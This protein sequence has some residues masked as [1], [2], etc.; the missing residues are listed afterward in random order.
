MA[1]SAVQAAEESARP[2]P[3]AS[4]NRWTR[5]SS[6]S[7]PRSSFDQRLAAARHRRLAR[8]RAHARRL[9]RDRAPRTWRRSNA[10]WRRCAPRSRAGKFAWSVEDEDVHL[11]I[12]RRLTELVGDAGKRLHTARSRNDQVAT[13]VRLWLRDEIDDDRRQAAQRWKRRCS[14][15]A[16]RHA[17]AGDARLHAPAGG[18]AGDLRPPPARLCRDVRARPRAARRLPQARQRA[19]AGRR[20]ARRHHLS[21]RPRAASRA[22]S[23][24]RA[25]RRTRSTRCRTATSPSNSPP[26]PRSS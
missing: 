24:S 4:P 18:A 15:Q 6:A 12:E 16:A 21:D 19:A 9:R 25:S 17:G 7:P 10:A 11:N 22:N 20:G 5:S 13:D 1:A 3:A 2:G 14:T 23:A 8:A 26:A